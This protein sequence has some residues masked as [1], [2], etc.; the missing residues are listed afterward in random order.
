MET[1]ELP[2]LKTW[3]KSHMRRAFRLAMG[4]RLTEADE[5]VMY[6]FIDANEPIINAQID[7]HN[8]SLLHQREEQLKAKD[9][10]LE[11]A[12]KNILDSHYTED[13]LR[14]ELK[15]KD[16]LLKEI[17]TFREDLLIAKDEELAKLTKQRDELL[18]WM[19]ERCLTPT[20][21]QQIDSLTSEVARLKELVEKAQYIG[22]VGLLEAPSGTLRKKIIELLTEIYSLS[23]STDKP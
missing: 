21:Q 1:N 6:D 12:Y 10:E 7:Q 5:K 3:I 4:N 11:R 15:A 2:E 17:K 22:E 14:N 19:G 16:E 18:Q 9:E 13:E 23:Q 8:V 20:G